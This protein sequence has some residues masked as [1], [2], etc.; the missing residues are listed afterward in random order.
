MTRHAFIA[1]ADQKWRQLTLI[2]IKRGYVY[3]EYEP[4]RRS[5]DNRKVPELLSKK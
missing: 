4:E 1:K 3:F 5:R 2:C